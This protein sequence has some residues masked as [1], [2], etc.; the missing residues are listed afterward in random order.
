MG[1]GRSGE[2]V[3]KTPSGGRC[4]VVAR[5]GDEHVT[6]GPVEPGQHDDLHAGSDSADRLGDLGLKGEPRGRR[7]LV[8]LPRSLRPV[9]QWPLHP[10]DR[11]DLI[12]RFP[13]H[14]SNVAGPAGLMND[15]ISPQQPGHGEI[16]RLHEKG[17]ADRRGSGGA[18]RRLLGLVGSG[19]LRP[20]TIV[21]E[22]VALE[23]AGGFISAMD[24][25]DKLGFTVI[26]RL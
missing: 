18:R 25:Y 20:R 11:Q 24:R 10:S 15:R 9:G 16:E 23:Q 1:L 22:T 19:V 5:T 21:A 26:T 8:S 17:R 7:A 2:R 12:A 13:H 14:R 4:G 6:A 3:L